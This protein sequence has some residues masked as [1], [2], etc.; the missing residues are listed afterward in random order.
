MIRITTG[1]AKNKILEIPNIDSFRG[2]QEKAKL[3]MFSMIGNKIEDS[4]CLDLFSG[5]GNLGI[6]SL[7]RGAE[8]CDFVDEEYECTKVIEKNLFNCGFLE[9]SQVFRKNSIKYIDSCT[10]QYDFIFM[11]PYYKDKAHRH[12]FKIIRNILSP[13]GYIYYFHSLNLTDEEISKI[14]ED[15]KLKSIDKRRFGESIFEVIT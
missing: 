14:L 2:V 12:L 3:S 13:D 11:D 6:E 7:S 9:K 4:I 5:S 8:W 15:T 1:S 10:K